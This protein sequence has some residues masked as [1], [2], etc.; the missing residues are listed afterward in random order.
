MDREKLRVA[1][2]EIDEQLIAANEWN[3]RDDARKF[4]EK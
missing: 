3:R 1:L 2:A 4:V